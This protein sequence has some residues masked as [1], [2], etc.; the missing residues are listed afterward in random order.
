MARI[1]HARRPE[2]DP[3]SMEAIRRSCATASSAA[4][5]CAECRGWRM[6]QER[7]HRF[8]SGL[9]ADLPGPGVRRA[10][11]TDERRSTGQRNADD[12]DGH[13]FLPD[14]RRFLYFWR[15][16]DEARQ[17]IY[18]ASLDV[19]G[20]TFVVRASQGA[21]YDR[22][23][24][25]L[26]VEGNRLVSAP[27]DVASA[28]ITGK[29]TEIVERLAFGVGTPWN[30]AHVSL[31]DTGVLAY[32]DAGTPMMQFKWFDRSGHERGVLPVQDVLGFPAVSHDGRRVAVEARDSRT[33]NSDIWVY[34]I[35][36]GIGHRITTHPAREYLP[37]WS[38]D[39]RS[40]AFSSNRRSA[41]PDLHRIDV[42]GTGEEFLFGSEVADDVTSWDGD[43]RYIVFNRE[44]DEQNNQG[45]W[46]FSVANRRRHPCFSRRIVCFPAACRRMDDGSRTPRADLTAMRYGFGACRRSPVRFA[47]ARAPIQRGAAMARSCFM[48]S[49]RQGPTKWW[50]CPFVQVQN[51]TQAPRCRYSDCRPGLSATSATTRALMG[52]AF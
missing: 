20:S 14:G 18:A 16:P 51:W 21:Y 34:D 7:H 1:F 45:L 43:G 2:E 31:S 15:T 28:R 10:L 26:F 48:S 29:A 47:L 46:L 17:G 13:L 40:I 12:I 35:E 42:N 44:G 33:G 19:P 9:R 49:L 8:Q 27:F 5:E 30:I 41:G 24:Y 3:R 11:H 22:S 32:V 37:H 52:S 4:S 25:L 23:G 36:R 6:E 39:D 38:P 50:R